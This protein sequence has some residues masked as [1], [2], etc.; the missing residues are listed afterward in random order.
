MP[1]SDFFCGSDEGLAVLCL[2]L[3]YQFTDN[4]LATTALTHRSYSPKASYERLEFLGDA[5]LGAIVAEY[6]YH[7]HPELDEGRL[8]RMRATLVRQETLVQ[9]AQKLQLYR[10]VILGVG[11]RKGGGRHRASILADV[12]EA[13]IGA[14]YSDSG[15]FD[16]TKACVLEWYGDMLL[17]VQADAVLKDAK[18]RLQELAQAQKIPLPS[19]TLVQT[20]G[21]S[22]NQTF[23]VCCQL[24]KEGIDPITEQGSSRRIAEQ[25]CAE[26]MINQLNI[27]L[28]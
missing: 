28:S 1:S 4:A 17:G 24:Q 18:S 20:L 13:L 25:K 12:V 3:G 6:L 14:I 5:L 21:N 2:A 7:A 11:E 15:D 16:T 19:Y 23:V 26:L 10:H 22:P 8:T 9:V 27:A